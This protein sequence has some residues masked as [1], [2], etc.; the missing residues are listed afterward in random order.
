MPFSC[1]GY[2]LTGDNEKTIALFEEQYKKMRLREHIEDIFLQY[3]KYNNVY[4]Y[5]WN[6]QIMTLP[7]HK[8]RIGNTLLNGTPIIDLDVQSIQNEF[9]ERTYSVLEAKGVKDDELD[10]VLKAYPPEVAQALKKGAQYATLSPDNVF[11][12]QGAKEGWT[13]YAVPWIATALPALAKKELISKYETALL[14]LGSRS[15]VHVPY[16]DSTKGMDI[17]PGAAELQQVRS[18]FSSAMKGNPLAVTNHLAKPQIIQA[19]LSDL[20]QWPLY[21]QVNAD[22]LAAGGISGI[23]VNGRS[24]EGSTFASAQIS[25]QAAGARI[26]AAR[27]EVEDLMTK[28]NQ[29]L[30]EDIKLTHTNNLKDIPEF[31]FLPVDMTGQK[32]LRE[33]CEKLWM[34]GL[35]STKTMMDMQGFS[36]SKE[37]EQREIEASDGTDEILAPRQTQATAQQNQQNQEDGNNEDGKKPVGRPKMDNDERN[38]DPENAIRSK[39]AKDAADG[40]FEDGA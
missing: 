10:A 18:I 30:V 34:T 1:T 9:R 13:R 11:V 4:V 33:T 12:L 6:G 2:Y 26:D 29:R 27:H 15:F 37:R 16:G 31:H 8:I 7:P 20:Y 14:N 40:D 39:Q 19:D 3:Y 21:E 35:V 32:A 24:E 25:M 28:V 5:I 38:S 23:I 17:L 36:M 22:I